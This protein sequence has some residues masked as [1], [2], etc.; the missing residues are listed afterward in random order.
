MAITKKMIAAIPEKN[1]GE[2]LEYAAAM[3][4]RARATEDCKKGIEAFLDK[5]QVK[6]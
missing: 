1:L 5:E 3:N 2:A 4:A 6:W